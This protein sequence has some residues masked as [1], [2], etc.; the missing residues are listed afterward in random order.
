L[1]I[2][3]KMTCPWQTM[4]NMIEKIDVRLFSMN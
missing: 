1:S 4:Q 2:A 3:N